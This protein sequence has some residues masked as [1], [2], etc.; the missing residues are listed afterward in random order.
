MGV[1]GFHER[2]GFTTPNLK[3]AETNRAF[4]DATDELIVLADHTK[5]GVTG[6]TTIARTRRRD[7]VRVR[8]LAVGP[9]GGAGRARRPADPRQRRPVHGEKKRLMATVTFEQAEPRVYQAGHRPA[10]DAL[11]LEIADGEFLVLVGPSG[12]GKIDHAADARRA[13]ADRRRTRSHRRP[14]RHRRCRRAT[15]T[16]RWCSRATRS[17]RT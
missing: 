5:W 8:R 17:T 16:S 3:E 6:L 13:R 15:A 7:G 4:V 2:A 1:H 10:V 9:R 11:D 12:C 14:R